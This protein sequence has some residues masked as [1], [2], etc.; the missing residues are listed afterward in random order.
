MHVNNTLILPDEIIT[1]ILKY[2]D[3]K[4]VIACRRVSATSFS[5][6]VSCVKLS[7]SLVMPPFQRGGGSLLGAPIYRRANRI[8]DVR[9][10]TKR[11]SASGAVKE[12]VGD[13]DRM[14]DLCVDF[15]R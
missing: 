1:N 14:E 10:P 7:A 15:D 11:Y 9:R 2:T 8:R 6:G 3:Y 12:I 4:T 5:C 13:A